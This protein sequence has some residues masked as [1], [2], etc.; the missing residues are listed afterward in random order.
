M[1]GP[2]PSSIG[3]LSELTTLA[4]SNNALGGTI[5]VQLTNLTKA[6]R[7]L[8][9]STNLTG[10]LPSTIGAMTALTQLDVAGNNLNGAIPAGLSSTS[11]NV[12]RGGNNK[13]TSLPDLSARTWSQLQLQNNLFAGSLPSWIGTESSLSYLLLGSNQFTGPIPLSWA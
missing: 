8:L 4:L 12:L 13:F 9:A 1:S 10:T 11:I 7:V 3:L 5:P 2:L 6:W